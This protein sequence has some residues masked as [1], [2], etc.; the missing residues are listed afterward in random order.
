MPNIIF[1]PEGF[2]V[3]TEHSWN[4][5]KSWMSI[6]YRQTTQW[7]WVLFIHHYESWQLKT[8]AL[9]TTKNKTTASLVCICHTKEDSRR[10]PDFSCSRSTIAIC[11]WRICWCILT[12]LFHGSLV[13]AHWLPL[14][15]AHKG[16][17]IKAHLHHLPVEVTVATHVPRGY[18]KA[19]VQLL[20]STCSSAA[21]SEEHALFKLV[22]RWLLRAGADEGL[23]QF[24]LAYSHYRD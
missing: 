20:Q 12:L 5:G 4:P 21:L 23:R 14:R 9:T 8:S 7:F 18:W 15:G 13:T 17:H 11:R 3:S 24:A 2:A 10:N 6:L 22:T 1:L 16:R 19:N